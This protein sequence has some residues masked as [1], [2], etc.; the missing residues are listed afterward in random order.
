MS[1][2]ILL[3][4]GIATDKASHA[5]SNGNSSL[6]ESLSDAIQELQHYLTAPRLL[7]LH[8]RPARQGGLFI[9]SYESSALHDTSSFDTS[10]LPTG[11]EA[12]VTIR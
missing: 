5:R 3:D 2:V 6:P 7:R 11:T 10:D 12:L 8:E 9:F 1:I 4:Y